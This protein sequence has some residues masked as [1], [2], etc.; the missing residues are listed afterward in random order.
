MELYSI[1]D[2]VAGSYDGMYMFAND[3]VA[4]R[5]FQ[6]MVTKGTASDIRKDLQLYKVGSF[7]QDSGM[8]FECTPV[9]IMKGSDISVPDEV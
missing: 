7:D 1:R 2:V 6:L 5:W 8:V 3:A 4:M 9:Q